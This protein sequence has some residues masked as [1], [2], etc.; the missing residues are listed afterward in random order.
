MEDTCEISIV[1]WEKSFDSLGSNTKFCIET[2]KIWANKEH[3]PDPIQRTSLAL[4]TW[5]ISNTDHFCW[6]RWS[7]ETM[8]CTGRS[9]GLGLL[10]ASWATGS[11]VLLFDECMINHERHVRKKRCGKTVPIS[12][13][14]NCH[15]A[16]HDQRHINGV[17]ANNEVEMLPF[18]SI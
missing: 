4:E 9:P 8:F 5:R 7:T 11:R 17:E 12:P 10:Q 14:P 18:D 3:E 2:R 1:V 15:L 13:V 16:L 6:L